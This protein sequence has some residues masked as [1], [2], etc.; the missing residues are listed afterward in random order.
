MVFEMLA[1]IYDRLNII[2]HIPRNDADPF[3]S[4]DLFIT[5]RKESKML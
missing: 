2:I 4:P 3:V 5:L 1:S